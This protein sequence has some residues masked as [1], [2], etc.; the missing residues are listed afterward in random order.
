MLRINLDETAICLYQGGGKGN[1]FLHKKDHGA[2]A[3]VERVSR[4]KR[5]TFLTHVA[6]VCDNAAIQAVLPQIVIGNEATLPAAALEALRSACPSN[7][8]LVRQ[9]SSWNDSRLCA[10]IVR[11]LAFA[12]RPFRDWFQPLLLLDAVRLHFA[13]VVLNACNNCGIWLL[14]IP[15]KTTW[16]LQPLDTH[17][18]QSFKAFL[19]GAYQKARVDAGRCDLSLAEFLLC[20]YRAIKAVLEDRHWG[21]AFTK[22][23]FGCCQ[24]EVREYIKRQI[25]IEGPVE[26]SASRPSLVQLQSVFPRRTVVPEASLWRPF[27]PA[28][29]AK[30]AAG[31]MLPAALVAAKGK[32]SPGPAPRLGRTRANHREAVAAQGG[33]VASAFAGPASASSAS[34]AG[35][36]V[37]VAPQFAIASRLRLPRAKASAEGL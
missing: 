15:A 10:I 5:R 20:L 21:D 34:S 17:V 30:A 4:G 16:L 31:P 11:I 18:F 37:A 6:F 19:R 13:Q 24:L 9:K 33:V 8:R 28:P 26:V 29:K 25:Q 3:A 36:A 22:N 23:G 32:A 1:V 35:E 7:V 27:N 2:E 12:L 14:L